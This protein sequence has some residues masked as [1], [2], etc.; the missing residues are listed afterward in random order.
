MDD[1]SILGLWWY[2]IVGILMVALMGGWVW[3]QSHQ[4]AAAY[5][6]VTG[7]GVSWWDAVWLDLRV[8]EP[9]Q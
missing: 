5:G 8:Q 6:R 9:V 7:K 3:I 2:V 1:D 4:E